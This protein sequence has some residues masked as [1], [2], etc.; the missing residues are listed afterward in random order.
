MEGIRPLWFAY[1]HNRHA[2]LMIIDILGRAYPQSA[3]CLSPRTRIFIPSSRRLDGKI[4]DSA[5]ETL[6]QFWQKAE[7]GHHVSPL[8]FP[9]T[10]PQRSPSSAQHLGVNDLW[11]GWRV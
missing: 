3:D 11:I 5:E 8:A 4:A 2:S 9:S 10:N 1:Y 7:I 6:Q